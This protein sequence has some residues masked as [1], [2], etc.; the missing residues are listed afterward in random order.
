MLL[1][2]GLSSSKPGLAMQVI[3]NAYDSLGDMNSPGLTPAKSSNA[4]LLVV[5]FNGLG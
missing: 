4:K 3:A 1:A 5:V 2:C